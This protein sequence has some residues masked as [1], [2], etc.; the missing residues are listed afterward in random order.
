MKTRVGSTERSDG[1]SSGS[2]DEDS[3]KEIQERVKRGKKSAPQWVTV[4]LKDN[5]CAKHDRACIKKNDKCTGVTL[6]K[7]IAGTWGILMVRTL[8]MINISV[9][10][11][12]CL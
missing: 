12:T 9:L 4:I 6:T 7:E 3:S 8:F 2:S 1:D 10:T 11:R 5:H